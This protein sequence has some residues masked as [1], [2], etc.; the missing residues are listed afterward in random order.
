MNFFMRG[1]FDQTS[2]YVI[3]E[4]IKYHEMV[5][6]GLETITKYN[7][8]LLEK[9][10]ALLCAEWKTCSLQVPKS[11]EAPFMKLIKM[12][13]MKS[14]VAGNSDEETTNV[15][16]RL[17]KDNTSCGDETPNGSK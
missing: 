8:S 14:Y 2:F 13:K 10:V 11:I 3:D 1:T 17:I 15:C 6:G 16:V 5:F 4:C 7:T 9:A 12:P